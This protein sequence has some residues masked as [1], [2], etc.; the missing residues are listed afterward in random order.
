M[1]LS[2]APFGLS[3]RD[4]MTFVFPQPRDPHMIEKSWVLAIITTT[5]NH[6]KI[7]IFSGERPLLLNELPGV[8]LRCFMFL[9]KYSSVFYH[10]IVNNL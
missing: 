4:R 2:I 8:T 3:K 6:I 1:F 7:K 9:N 5:F 10:S